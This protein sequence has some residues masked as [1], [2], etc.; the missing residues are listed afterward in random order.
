M[1]PHVCGVGFLGEGKYLSS[2]NKKTTKYFN[3]WS[4]MIQRCYDS[5]TQN[6]HPSYKGC[7]VAEDWHNFQN[8]AKWYDENYYEVNSERM[9]LDK[10]ILIKGNKTYSKKNCIIVP[11]NINILFSNRKADRGEYPIGVSY[12]K[13]K[14]QATCNNPFNVK[15]EGSYLGIY[16]TPLEAFKIYKQTKEKYIRQIALVYKDRIPVEL[17][18]ALVKYEVEI[19]D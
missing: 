15:N 8:F 10:D 18:E 2:K 12:H 6:K 1:F 9:E 19:D 3:V 7:K 4:K 11:K 14:F 5:E 16:N 17:Y 13:G